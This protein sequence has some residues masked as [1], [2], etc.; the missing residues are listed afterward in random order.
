MN[1]NG[2]INTQRASQVAQ[3]ERIHLQS[4]RCR[5]T[6]VRSVGWEDSLEE[7][8]ATHS[9]ILAWRIP[10]R[11]ETG[12]LESIGSRRVRQDWSDWAN[13]AAPGDRGVVLGS[14]RY[15]G[16]GNGNP[17]QYSCQADS[18]SRGFWW[19]TVHGVAK[20]QTWLNNWACKSIQTIS[21]WS[22]WGLLVH[23]GFCGSEFLRRDFWKHDLNAYRIKWKNGVEDQEVCA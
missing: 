10:W 19:A 16:G 1:L 18:M 17:L 14:G 13:A 2:G 12:G 22:Y 23:Q 5:Q 3:W 9:S 20:S 8:L 4:R 21:S 11:E 6:W 7:G 15:P